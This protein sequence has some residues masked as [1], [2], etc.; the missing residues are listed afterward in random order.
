MDSTRS[1]ETIMSNHTHRQQLARHLSQHCAISY[2]RALAFV[3]RAAERG[4][5]PRTLDADGR[6]AA[7]AG[8]IALVERD[9]LSAADTPGGPSPQDDSLGAVPTPP[10]AG[11]HIRLAT[12]VDGTPVSVSHADLCLHTIVV[13]ASSGGTRSV[14]PAFV[15]GALSLGSSVTVIDTYTDSQFEHASRRAATTTGAAFRCFGYDHPNFDPFAGVRQRDLPAVAA[16]VVELGGDTYWGRVAAGVFRDAVAAAHADVEA[17]G[18]R[19]ITV[20]SLAAVLASAVADDEAEGRTGDAAKVRVGALA[21]MRTAEQMLPLPHEEA[22]PFPT[23]GGGVTYVSVESSAIG[24]LQAFSALTQTVSFARSTS[25]PPLS[26]VVISGADR[27]DRELILDLMDRARSLNIALVL[28]CEGPG[29]WGDDWERVAANSNVFVVGRQASADNAARCASALAPD[30]ASVAQW[31]LYAL[32]S[33]RVGD[34]IVGARHRVEWCET[35][36]LLLP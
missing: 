32:Q 9:A 29:S 15:N 4:L 18:A 30:R 16:A 5:L 11:T 35:G 26:F 20:A 27:L 22:A 2:Q 19:G 10:S 13:G 17:S 28:H 12:K 1:K 23:A 8:L 7:L 33:A 25:E 21:K 31:D 6:A 24:R 36:R 34:V 14:L 3:E